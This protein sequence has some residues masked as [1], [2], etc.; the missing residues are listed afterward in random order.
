MIRQIEVP[1]GQLAVETTGDDAA[2]PVV[3]LHSGVADRRM[4]DG[5]VPALAERYRVV[6]HDMTGFG[7]ST[8]PTGPYRNTDDLLAVLDAVGAPRA[9]VIGSSFGG[10]VSLAFAV[11]RPERVAALGLL[12]APLP[13]HDWSAA[14]AEY[15]AAEEAAL[16][17]ADLDA[18]VSSNLDMWVRGPARS[19][20]ETLRRHAATVREAMRV[21]LANQQLTETHERGDLPDVDAALA[22]LGVPT[23]V[24]VGEDDLP[25]FHTI[26][27][28]LAR[29]IRGAAGP[30]R[31]PAVGHLI[32]VE[33]PAVT[34]EL[35][36]TFLDGLDTFDAP[37][38]RAS[39]DDPA[40]LGR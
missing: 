9:A 3:L 1:Q 13:D 12:A 29:S 17:R 18:A 4:W 37:A 39:R 27:D 22:G 2:P 35:L 15:A 25:D 20:D 28:R 6:R 24:A 23:L 30:H 38:G 11:E 31:L 7:E 21:A 34:A 33:Q 36:R 40:G 16:A 26:A 10:L 14:M 32:P 8:P 19:W 5:V